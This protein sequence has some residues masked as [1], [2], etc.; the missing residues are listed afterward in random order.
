MATG[1]VQCAPRGH[2]GRVRVPGHPQRLVPRGLDAYALPRLGDH[3]GPGRPGPGALDLPRSPEPGRGL[4]W[5]A[6]SMARPFPGFSS[7]QLT[8]PA[9]SILQL[10]I[11]GFSIPQ[12]ASPG[13]SILKLQIPC[14][15]QTEMQAVACFML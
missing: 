6:A 10:T 11:P 7:L 9:F 8:I 1:A 3:A 13:F 15:S 5:G 2:H 4:A 12:L 14:F